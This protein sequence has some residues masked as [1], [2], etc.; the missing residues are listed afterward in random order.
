MRWLSRRGEFIRAP[1]GEPVRF[2]GTVYDIT[3]RKANEIKQ[4]V[5]LQLAD[6]LRETATV[7]S[8]ITIAARSLGEN[9]AVSSAGY[10][11]IDIDAGIFRLEGG[12][13][14]AE[15]ERLT[16]VFTPS[17]FHATV[18][19]LKRGAALVTA[20]VAS[21]GWLGADIERYEKLGVRSLIAIPFIHHDKLRT[22]F[23][24]FD[25]VPRNWRSEEIDFTE[26]VADLT[27]ATVARLEAEADQRFLNIEL[28]HRLKNS[29][30]VVQAIASQT[31]NNASDK[32]AVEAFRKRLTALS[33]AHDIL[34]QQ[35][36]TS[37][38][39]K[40][41]IEG[42][43]ALHVD[44]V[45]V[46]LSGPNVSIGPKAVLSLSLLMNELATNAVKYGALSTADG[47]LTISWHI[48]RGSEQ[49]T[50]VMTW[51]ESGGPPVAEPQTLG[52]GTRLIKAGIS[53]TG[54]T[55]VRYEASGFFAEFRAP[56]ALIADN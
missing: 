46:S 17:S 26:A 35:S 31:L 20:N 56:F 19:H 14:K 37:A 28:S 45:R 49:P 18:S 32:D 24:V 52:L 5:L 1:N 30:A 7:E 43:M 33:T 38:R 44:L 12:W 51:T 6:Q 15:G 53:G 48:E 22:V 40:P 11:V 10:A 13:A 54:H 50:F 4:S 27:Y 47:Q 23:F 9:L 55:A 42:L 2:T 25:D 34:L 36:W 16:G 41:L 29:L 3:A 39:I 21:V 8:A